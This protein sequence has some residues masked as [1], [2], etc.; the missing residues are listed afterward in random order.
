ML[1]RRA[2][3]RCRLLSFD[4]LRGCR[5]CCAVPLRVIS[6]RLEADRLPVST[7]EERGIDVGGQSA[8]SLGWQRR[9]E[10][11]GVDALSIG[12]AMVTVVG[13]SGLMSPAAWSTMPSFGGNPTRYSECMVEPHHRRPRRSRHLRGLV[14]APRDF[15]FNGVTCCRN[16]A[17]ARASSSS[18]VS[19]SAIVR[20]LPARPRVLPKWTGGRAHGRTN[21]VPGPPCVLA[22]CPSHGWRRWSSWA[23]SSRIQCSSSYRSSGASVI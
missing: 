7:R 12:T 11:T 14:A 1:A 3:R 21:V 17:I 2:A 16:S 15:E 5:D 4:A 20:H 8:G 10:H 6:R 23:V 9:V 13:R 22:H 19:S 18:A